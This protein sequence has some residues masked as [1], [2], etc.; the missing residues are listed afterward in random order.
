MSEPVT[1][2]LHMRRIEFD[3]VPELSELRDGEGV[4]EI[5]TSFGLDAWLVTRFSDV[6]EVLADAERFSN[7]Y[8]MAR[9][10]DMSVEEI[11]KL[12]AGNLIGFDPPEH[13][14]LRR[15]LAPEFTLR[16]IRRLEP[17]IREIVTDHLD[18][19]ERAGSPAD[20]VTSFALP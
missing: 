8:R 17:R 2:P 14:R 5:T 18:A 20:L 15:M 7:V 10:L 19:M 9:P 13:T 16:R 1:L 12:Q 3:P 6:R 4:R 11:R